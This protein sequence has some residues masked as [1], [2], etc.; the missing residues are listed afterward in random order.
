MIGD[1]FLFDGYLTEGISHRY[2]PV[3]FTLKIVGFTE[4]QTI[5]SV[6]PA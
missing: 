3:L 5:K 2:L 1:E 4:K 6:D